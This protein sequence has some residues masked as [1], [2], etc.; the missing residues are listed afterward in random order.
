MGNPKDMVKRIVD[1]KLK[2]YGETDVA[3]GVIRVNKKRHK[4]PYWERVNRNKDGSECL[5][6]TYLHEELHLKYPLK[7]EPEIRKLVKIR[8]S[9]MTRQQKNRLYAKYR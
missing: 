9:K 5:G 3:N 6:M 7:S 1:N 2:A 4:S 8:W